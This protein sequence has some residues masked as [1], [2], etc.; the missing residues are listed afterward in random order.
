[1][2]AMAFNPPVPVPDK[3][4]SSSTKIIKHKSFADFEFRRSCYETAKKSRKPNTFFIE[5]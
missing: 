3:K 2:S 4:S 1:M 5:L